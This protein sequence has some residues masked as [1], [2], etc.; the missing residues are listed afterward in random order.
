MTAAVPLTIQPSNNQ[1]MRVVA[2][3]VL[4]V[5]PNVLLFLALSH[6]N[7]LNHPVVARVKLPERSIYVASIE[8]P[9]TSRRD[10]PEPSDQPALPASEEVLTVNLDVFEPQVLA[11]AP[12]PLMISLDLPVA[13]PVIAN[14]LPVETFSTQHVDEMPRELHLLH[15]RYPSEARRLGLEGW[16]EVRLLIDEQGRVVDVR[17]ERSEGS[18]LFVKAIRD[19]ARTWRFRP[20]RRNGTPVRVWGIKRIHF[21]L[22]N[23]R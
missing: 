14:R 15:P 21:N 1:V 7:T 5:I 4:A 20:A 2:S 10:P 22:E 6:L 17:I 8:P 11:I 9:A 13:E 16:V 19:V 18:E 12:I 3:I 23:A